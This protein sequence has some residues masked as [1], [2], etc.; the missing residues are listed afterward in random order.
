MVRGRIADLCRRGLASDQ[1]VLLPALLASS[2]GSVR[3]VHIPVLRGRMARKRP[4]IKE[5]PSMQPA[6]RVIL[7]LFVAI[8]AGIL[9]WDT[10]HYYFFSPWTRDARV[11]ADVVKVAPDVSGYVA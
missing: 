9:G 4:L 2:I 5:K 6:V 1:D 3:I 7:T 8:A 10:V 11:T